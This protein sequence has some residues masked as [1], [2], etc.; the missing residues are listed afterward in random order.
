MIRSAISKILTDLKRGEFNKESTGQLLVYFM[1]LVESYQWNPKKLKDCDKLCEIASGLISSF[2]YRGE[3]L[4]STC[5]KCVT[6]SFWYVTLLHQNSWLQ[7]R[8]SK[9][10]RAENLTLSSTADVLKVMYRFTPS[11]KLEFQN[12]L[13]Q[14]IR[15]LG[16]SSQLPAKI[17]HFVCRLGSN[18]VWHLS[19]SFQKSDC[20]RFLLGV[21]IDRNA[22]DEIGDTP[23]IIARERPV[24][25]IKCIKIMLDAGAHID[26]ANEKNFSAL[27]ILKSRLNENYFEIFP[28][29]NSV[30][31]LQCRC[32]SVIRQNQI[33]F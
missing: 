9:L 14:F 16:E 13:S 2:I 21:G 25:D 31:P 7:N 8:S 19:S 5:L 15:E 24:M 28:L 6:F 10:E 27:N 3:V 23:L 18:D 4:L 20:I 22:V 1:K 26:L 33:F 29:I 11:E 17:I 12:C 32:A 30:R